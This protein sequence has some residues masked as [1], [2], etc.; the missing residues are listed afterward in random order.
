M[1]HYF[2]PT[3][4]YPKTLFMPSV[5]DLS[6]A[7]DPNARS[8]YYP[9]VYSSVG[10]YPHAAVPSLGDLPGPGYQAGVRGYPGG[11]G[12]VGDGGGGAGLYAQFRPPYMWMEFEESLPYF[13]NQ[14]HYLHAGPAA[15]L[16]SPLINNSYNHTD[17]VSN[18]NGFPV[19]GADRLPKADGQLSRHETKSRKRRVPTMAQRR[20]ANVRERRRMFSLNEAFDRLRRRIPTFAYE[21][22]LS[23][24]E[25]LRLA[26]S[27]IGFMSEIVNGVDPSQVESGTHLIHPVDLRSAGDD[28]DGARNGFQEE[29]V[30]RNR[31]VATGVTMSGEMNGI[32]REVP[33]EGIGE[34]VDDEDLDDFDVEEE[35]DDGVGEVMTELLLVQLTFDCQRFGLEFESRLAA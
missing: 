13:Q 34:D 1:S 22:R 9:E 18:H 31:D 12:D 20:A 26:I 29:P 25:T 27:Y 8:S 5:S 3:S 7:A 23:R 33:D 2:C 16:A 10:T 17:A 35:E 15:G 24:I 4:A 11:G 32:G 30:P 21:K 14:P 28:L 19:L 6:P